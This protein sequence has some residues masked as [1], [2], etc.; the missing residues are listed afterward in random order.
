MV[1]ECPFCKEENPEDAVKCKKCQILFYRSKN[2]SSDSTDVL[3]VENTGEKVSRRKHRWLTW[4]IVSSVAIVLIIFLLN[5]FGISSEGDYPSGKEKVVWPA[6]TSSV[7]PTATATSGLINKNESYAVYIH[8]K[9]VQDLVNQWLNSW[10]VGD[11]K[12]YRACYA[13]DFRSQGKNLNSWI[14]H[15]DRVFRKSKKITIAIDDLQI[16]VDG[17]KAKVTFL[18]HYRSSIT[19]DSVRKTL[20]LKKVNDEWKIFREIS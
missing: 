15:K 3:N 4:A 17:D 5:I 9:D 1:M 10:Q 11:S 14:A 6:R 19:K 12:T 2:H 8:Q 20:H 16:A 7:T 18:Q 13:D